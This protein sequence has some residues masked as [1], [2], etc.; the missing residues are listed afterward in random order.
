MPRPS[1]AL[2]A[3]AS[4][5]C[6]LFLFTQ[7]SV[8]WVS[9]LRTLLAKLKS[10]KTWN[11]ALSAKTIYNLMIFS[12]LKCVRL[13]HNPRRCRRYPPAILVGDGLALPL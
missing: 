8:C 10:S 12:L 2:D 3:K 7:R 6:P 9:S 5:L 1:S 13:G 4:A 11:F